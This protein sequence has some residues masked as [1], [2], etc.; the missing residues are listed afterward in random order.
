MRWGCS[1]CSATTVGKLFTHTCLCYYQR[2]Q[3]VP[4]E[5]GC[6]AAG[7]VTVGLASHWPC[8]TDFSGLSTCGLGV[9]RKRNEHPAY[10]HS[11]KGDGTLRIRTTRCATA[12][13]LYTNVDAQR[14][15]LATVVSRTKL[16][17]PATVDVARR[18]SECRTNFQRGVHLPK[19]PEI[20]EFP[21]NTTVGETEESLCL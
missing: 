6:P 21:S 1:A 17:A 8:V 16:T 20:P 3:L 13:V 9:Y 5:G 18:S 4:V 10:K 12:V 2:Q 14:D 19:F 7:K 15:K 11:S